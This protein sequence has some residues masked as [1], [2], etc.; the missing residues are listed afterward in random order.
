MKVYTAAQIREIDAYTIEHEPISSINLMERAS[1]AVAKEIFERWGDSVSYK[2]FA[3]PGNNGGDALAVSRLLAKSGCRVSVYLFNT[4]GNLSP[5][6]QTNKIRL[7]ESRNVNFVEVTSSFAPPVLKSEDV[8]I[9]GLFGTGVNRPLSGGFAGVVKYINSSDA[10]IVSIDV[11]S[12]LMCEDNEHNV[13]DHIVKADYTFTFQYPKL[14]FF[15]P[16]N[17]QFVGKW[18]VLDIKLMDPQ[19][20]EFA[21]PYSVTEEA[22]A[23]PMLRKRSRFAHKGTAGNAVLVAGKKGMVGAGIL[24]SRACLRSGVGK[25]T[26]RTQECNVLPLQ[27]AVPEAVLSIESDE[28]CFSHSFPMQG[29]DAIA[30][31]PGIGKE[32]STAQAM[33]EQVKLAANVPVVLDADAINILG[34]HRGWILQL[35]KECILTPHKKELFGLIGTSVNTYDQL[36]KTRELCSRQQIYI[37]IKGAFSAVVCPDGSVCF[38]PTGNQG[39]ATA[40]SGDVLTGVILALLAQGYDADSAVKLGVYLHGLAG[41]VA[42]E[43][44]GYEGLIASDIVE[45]LPEAFLRLRKDKKK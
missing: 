18:S 44:R 12:G 22:I 27:I 16:E 1:I 32:P 9:D 30:I 25:V 6:C 4:K 42:S 40:G 37:V 43:T 36:C 3:G 17:E 24:A 23:V 10:T 7:R 5:D 13:A 14:A 45:S 15:F 34:E 19:T 33:I 26:V 21:T 29:F 39:M 28:A 38:N 2:V 41:D 8:V 31:G 11:P 20:E 35:P